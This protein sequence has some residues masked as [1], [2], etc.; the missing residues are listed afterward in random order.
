MPIVPVVMEDGYSARG[1][2]GIITAG[3]LWVP[4][5]EAR[6]FD[7]GIDQ[8]VQQIRHALPADE[9]DG[10]EEGLAG[11]EALFTAA[12]MKEG[13]VM[14]HAPTLAAP[15]HALPRTRLA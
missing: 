2:L 8:L 14:K 12:E 13:N 1:W 9:E 3:A 10:D 5:Y 15:P 11:G 7:V 6:R 4:L